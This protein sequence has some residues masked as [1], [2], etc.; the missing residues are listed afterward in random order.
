[1]QL[2]TKND[3]GLEHMADGGEILIS[4]IEKDGVLR[5]EVVDTGLSFS[6]EQPSGMGCPT[7]GNVY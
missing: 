5:L 7:S 6:E 3:F 4:G 2:R 1:M